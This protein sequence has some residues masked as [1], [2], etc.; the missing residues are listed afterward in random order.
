MAGVKISSLVGAIADLSV[1]LTN[2][3]ALKILEDS[4]IPESATRL[5]GVLFPKPDGFISGFTVE[6]VTYGTDGLE[7]MDVRYTMTYVF[8]YIPIGSNRSL[9]DNYTVLVQDTALILNEILT[10]DDISDGIDLRLADVLSFGAV[11]D[12]AGNM[13]YGTEIQLSVTEFYEV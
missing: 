7:R 6:P 3:K 2:G 1:T 13:F 12:P 10:N 4:E 11:S 9:G 5:G 8:C